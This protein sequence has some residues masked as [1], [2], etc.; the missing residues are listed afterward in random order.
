MNGE[1]QL[2]GMKIF[3][4]DNDAFP[5]EQLKTNFHWRFD[6]NQWRL[7]VAKFLLETANA[8]SVKKWP[9]AIFSVAGFVND[10]NFSI[11]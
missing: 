8:G 6:G 7:D 1:V 3:H 9:E 11:K 10:G 5:I 4:H 2:Q